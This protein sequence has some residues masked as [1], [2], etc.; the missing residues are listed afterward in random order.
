MLSSFEGLRAADAAGIM[1]DLDTQ[2]R[3]EV[4]DAL[5]DDRL[6]DVIQEMS[7][8]DQK[9]LLAHLDEASAP[10]TSSRR[11]TPTTPPTCWPSC[12]TR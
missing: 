11:W 3:Y 8:E 2:L 1:R 5:D 4:A 6:A 12:R 10:R 7:E 9:E